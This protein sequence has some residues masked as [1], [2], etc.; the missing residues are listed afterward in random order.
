M[1]EGASRFEDDRGVIQDILGPVDAVTHIFTRQ[2]AVRGNHVHYQTT[3][4]TLV[5]SGQLLIVTDPDKADRP[6]GYQH[7]VYGPG[8]MACEE[9]GVPH[10]WKALKDTQVLV[11]TKGPRSGTDYE[12][13]TVRLETPLL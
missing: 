4:W 12:K 6:G 7:A 5:I 13:D 8:D 1:T 11:F 9:A 10:A 2:G 3:Q